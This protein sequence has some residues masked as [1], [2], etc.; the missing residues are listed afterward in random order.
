MKK[1]FNSKP[2]RI[3]SRIL[4]TTFAILLILYL[5]FVIVQRVTGNKS[6]MG[7]RLFVVATG[8]MSGAYEVNDVIAVKDWDIKKL[9]VGDD[10]AYKGNRGGLDGKLVTHR[11]IRIEK[12]EDGKNLFVTKGIAAPTSDPAITEDQILGK[13]MGIVPVISQVNHVVKT[14]LGFFLFVFCPLV[15]VIVLEVLQTITDIQIENNELKR[16]EKKEKEEVL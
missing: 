14:Q 13:V 6:I 12:G 1:I 16:I 3:I 2:Y 7:Y 15:L 10:I 4:E 5:S 8:S 11:I 9:K